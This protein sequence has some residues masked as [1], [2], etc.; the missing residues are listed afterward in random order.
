[1]IRRPPR[2]TLTD[3]LLPCTT[4]FLSGAAYC[5][6]KAALAVGPT[7]SGVAL[8]MLPVAEEYK[9]ILIVEPAVADAITGE[10]WNKY[11]FRTSRNSTQDAYAAAAA[12]PKERSEE[13][14]VG[15]ECVSTCRSRWSP[16]H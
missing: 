6:D 1:M 8:A 10:K 13:R 12:F 7:A 2:S 11:I 15:K 14:R 4:L 16:Y 9:K 3:T 5:D